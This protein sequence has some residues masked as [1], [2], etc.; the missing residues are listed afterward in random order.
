MRNLKLIVLVPAAALSAPLDLGRSAVSWWEAG[1][2]QA[3]WLEG[4]IGSPGR[5]PLAAAAA[6][7]ASPGVGRHHPGGRH[8]PLGAGRP[9]VRGEDK[10]RRQQMTCC[11]LLLCGWRGWGGWVGCTSKGS[12]DRKTNVPQFPSPRSKEVKP[13]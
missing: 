10:S 2:Q 9:P 3:P 8:H 1:R 6:A 13:F 4:G 11:Y 7:A 12:L 5:S